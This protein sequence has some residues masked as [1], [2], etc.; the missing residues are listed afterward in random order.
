[1]LATSEDD[2]VEVDCVF[3][4]RLGLLSRG[5]TMKR[6]TTVIVIVVGDEDNDKG[7]MTLLRFVQTNSPTLAR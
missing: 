2:A 7:T 1:M 3:T 6:K 5:R 4:T